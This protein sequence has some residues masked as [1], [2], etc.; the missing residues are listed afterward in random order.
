MRLLQRIHDSQRYHFVS[1]APFG[2]PCG[3]GVGVGSGQQVQLQGGQV[4]P[5]T[6]AAHAQPQPPPSLPGTGVIATQ[7]PLGGHGS[8][9]HPIPSETH[10]QAC[11]VSAQQDARSV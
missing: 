1:H 9:E 4:S 8:V 5:D 3:A 11:A 6:H 7:R 2:L 10:E